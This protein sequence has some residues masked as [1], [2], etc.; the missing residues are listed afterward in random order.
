M[1]DEKKVTLYTG[2]PN[3]DHKG[4]I[5]DTTIGRWTKD[6]VLRPRGS[7]KEVLIP[8]IGILYAPTWDIVR[9]HQKGRISD[10]EYT[11]KYLAILRSRYSKNP[12]L[13]TA[14]LEHDEVTVTCF[15]RPGKFCHRH[16][17]IAVFAKIA[18]KHGITVIGGGEL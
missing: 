11:E 16:L 7:K 13:F 14:P 9:G 5:L 12:K 1:S 10:V 4:L 17:L 2:R 15:C 18:E 3:S 8:N 6:T